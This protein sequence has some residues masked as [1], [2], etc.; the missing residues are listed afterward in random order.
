MSPENKNFRQQTGLLMSLREQIR[1][2]DVG[3]VVEEA[4][5][6]DWKRAKAREWMGV[7]LDGLFECSEKGSVVATS[8]RAI[9]ECVPTYTTQ[10]GLPRARYSGHS[11]V[12]HLAAEA[13]RKLQ[14]IPG[15][16]PGL[17]PSP[18]S[19]SILQTPIQPTQPYASST[20]PNIPPS[21]L[22]EPSD[23]GEYNPYSQSQTYTPGQ[24]ARLSSFDQSTPASPTGSS[25]FTP[26][27]PQVGSYFTASRQ[28]SLSA[29]REHRR[30][31]FVG[32]VGDGTPQPSSEFRIDDIPELPPSPPSLPIRPPTDQL[33]QKL[34]AAEKKL[35]LYAELAGRLQAAC[36]TGGIGV[37]PTETQAADRY[38]AA[39]P[40]SLYCDRDHFPPQGTRFGD[41]QRH[42]GSL[43]L[44]L[45][46]CAGIRVIIPRR[47]TRTIETIGRLE[48]QPHP[49]AQ[50]DQMLSHLC[51][52]SPRN[53]R[54]CWRVGA[55]Q[56]NRMSPFQVDFFPFSLTT[57]LTDSPLRV[58]HI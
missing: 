1:A 25:P 6:G 46:W 47:K 21:D 36:D 30:V 22:Y 2:L 11:H 34:A 55:K 37:D 58:F 31:S 5:L 27:H 3:I 41:H 4:S 12:Q 23:F 14:R 16:I 53:R 19:L 56:R 43:R 17:S 8:G 20:L 45:L 33:A 13:E 39:R 51:L 28:P 26:F 38:V 40:S 24:R 48:W 35:A 52:P 32:E 50:Q 49:Q 10:P 29:G 7:L 18:P 54:C 42:I 57:C 9:I 15:D 44:S